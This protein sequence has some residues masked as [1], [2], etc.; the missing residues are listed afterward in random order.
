[1]NV[2]NSDFR[3]VSVCCWWE[4]VCLKYTGHVISCALSAHQTPTSRSFK[5]NEMNVTL[6]TPVPVVLAVY[7]PQ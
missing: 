1:M 3:N 5:G 2:V 7:I 6:G 4:F